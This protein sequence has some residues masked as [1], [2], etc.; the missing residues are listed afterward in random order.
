MKILF[1]SSELAPER[2]GGIATYIATI[3]PA[4]AARGHEV[5]VLSCAPE[6]E[7]RDD[8]AD[9]VWWHRRRLAGGDRAMNMKKYRQTALRLA[10]SFSCRRELA[11]LGTRFDVIE[12]PE[13]LAEGLLLGAMK[14]TPIVINLHT[15]LH[16]LFSFDVRGFNLDLRM[17]DRIE[18]LA[19]RRA[20]AVTSTSELLADTLCADGWLKRRPRIIP[21]PVDVDTWNVGRPVGDTKPVIL[22]VGRLEPRKSPDVAVEAA[23]LL[24]AE[25]PDLELVFVGRSRGYHKRRPYGEF[26]A[27]LA[28]K[29]NVRVRLVPQMTNLEVRQLYAEARVVAVPSLFESFSIAAL[30]GIASGR[31]VVYTSRIGAAEVLRGSDVGTEVPPSDPEA[32]AAALKPFL[33]DATHA[34]RAGELARD[35]ARSKCGPDIIALER[36]R[37]FEDALAAH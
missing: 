20:R 9:G 35:L 25:I 14:A 29:R 21:Y 3:A 7:S 23:A 36:E 33:A 1:L 17:A 22:V 37:C 5:H 27:E 34:A 13:W 10:T 2:A 12:S 28:E 31:P 30:E 4:M 8:Q 24:T 11:R 6:H 18:R 15:P 32:L 19:L 26:V 16:V